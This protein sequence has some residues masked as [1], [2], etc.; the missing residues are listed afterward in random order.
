MDKSHFF[1]HIEYSAING[2]T[3]KT[4]YLKKAPFWKELSLKKWS[5]C[6]PEHIK[7]NSYY[8]KTHGKLQNEKIFDQIE[9]KISIKT[10]E[11]PKIKQC[12]LY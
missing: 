5:I 11:T 6:F 4:T 10:I 1:Y 2:K 7:Y 12:L 9:Q 8:N 3:T